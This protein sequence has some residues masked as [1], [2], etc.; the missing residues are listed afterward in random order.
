L[1]GILGH[2]ADKSASGILSFGEG[3]FNNFVYKLKKR[4]TEEEIEEN[5]NE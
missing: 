1:L 3:I 4:N 5:V 2:Y